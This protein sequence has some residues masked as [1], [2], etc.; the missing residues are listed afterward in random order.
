MIRQYLAR[1]KARAIARRNAMAYLDARRA[2]REVEQARREV[3]QARREN[4]R[5]R[6]LIYQ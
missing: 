1:R 6:A 5:M 4:R 2:R 3:E